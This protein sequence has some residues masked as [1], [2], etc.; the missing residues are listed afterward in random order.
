MKR[1]ASDF[2]RVAPSRGA[3]QGHCV[4]PADDGSRTHCLAG[5]QC[6]G[7]V[8]QA[9]LL[10]EHGRLAHVGVHE[11]RIGADHALVRSQRR[12]GIAFEERV[13][14]KIEELRVIG[15]RIRRT[16]RCHREARQI[17]RG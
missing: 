16:L 2:Y 12:G 15:E 6:I 9:T 10:L 7:C 4:V 13:S 11:P 1:R 3:H 8:G 14:K 5:N 17:S